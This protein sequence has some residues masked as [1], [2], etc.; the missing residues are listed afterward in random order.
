MSALS[1]GFWQ[2]PFLITLEH[3]LICPVSAR[4]CVGSCRC[5]GSFAG[6]LHVNGRFL[7]SDSLRAQP[8]MHVACFDKQRRSANWP[9]L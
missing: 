2:G 6:I 1:A 3:E 7:Q 5:A 4:L 9:L 8:S